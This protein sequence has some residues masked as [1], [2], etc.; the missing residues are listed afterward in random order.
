M[1]AGDLVPVSALCTLCTGQMHCVQRRALHCRAQRLA[2]APITDARADQRPRDPNTDAKSTPRALKPRTKQPAW[3]SCS[4]WVWRK[5]VRVQC[6]QLGELKATGA[7]TCNSVEKRQQAKRQC[8]LQ[9]RGMQG[10]CVSMRSTQVTGLWCR[11]QQLLPCQQAPPPV[12]LLPPT[13][14]AAVPTYLHGSSNL[15]FQNG[16]WYVTAMLLI[17]MWCHPPTGPGWGSFAGRIAAAAPPPA[18]P[19]PL[20]LL[21]LLLPCLTRFA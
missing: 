4:G 17:H 20:R 11:L 6:E 5:V 14:D 16:L 12:R 7:G 10:G 1:H 21:W 9:T 15:G 2:V 19:P 13:P 18:P 8:F 3:C